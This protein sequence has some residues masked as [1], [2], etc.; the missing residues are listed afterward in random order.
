MARREK[1]KRNRTRTAGRIA[2]L[3]ADHEAAGIVRVWR[4][5]LERRLKNRLRSRVSIQVHDNTHTMVTFQRE[6]GYW[7]LRLH[8][9]FLAAPE[10]VLTAL[11]RFVEHG[12]DDSSG[13]LDRFIERNRALIRK[14]R[15]AELRRRIRIRP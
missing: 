8:H 5:V 7:R 10:L 2:R 3:G 15:P 12:D 9:M 4:R 14:V 11:A 1:R 6:R 13:V